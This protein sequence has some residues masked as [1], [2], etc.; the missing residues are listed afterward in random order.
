MKRFKHKR[1][2]PQ[3]NSQINVT[4]LVDVMLVL[5]IIFILI[6]PLIEH[7]VKIALPKAEPSEIEKTPDVVI[8]VTK[9]QILLN[10]SPYQLDQLKSLLTKRNEIDPQSVISVQADREIQYQK[11]IEV[12]DTVRL[13]GITNVALATDVKVKK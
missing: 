12:L 8:K 3:V 1:E 5:L 2:K 4:S 9:T 7:G 11:V 13:S 6:A 10:D